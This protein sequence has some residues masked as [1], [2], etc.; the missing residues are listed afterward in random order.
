MKAVD[1]ARRTR[2]RHT[3][4]I[5]TA[6]KPAWFCPRASHSNSQHS[7]R[8]NA[9]PGKACWT[10]SLNVVKTVHSRAGT[11]SGML[12]QRGLG[13][14][15]TQALL[16]YLLL[17]A[18]CGGWHLWQRRYRQWQLRGM[19]ASCE[20][21]NGAH[22]CSAAATARTDEQ[23]N[24]G[25]AM[26][27]HSIDS[28][29]CRAAGLGASCLEDKAGC[30][31]MACYL[32]SQTT[33]PVA[34]ASGDV[35]YN[36]YDGALVVD[37]RGAPEPVRA[38]ANEMGG[39]EVLRLERDTVSGPAPGPSPFLT[40]PWHW[41]ASLAVCDVQGN[42]L[43]TKVS[44]WLQ[45]DVKQSF[46]F[47]QKKVFT[48]FWPFQPVQCSRLELLQQPIIHGG[49]YALAACPACSCL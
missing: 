47:L 24:G 43:V 37:T 31:N 32:D 1:A 23:Q 44:T 46:Y 5:R 38:S 49:N 33:V 8:Y 15:T 6:G 17:A 13:A 16:N 26:R 21:Q 3:L 4:F 7:L 25:R 41:Y 19:R 42:F 28:N 48:S 45:A 12:A 18:T 9:W 34:D 40:H 30:S 11:T 39:C 22:H 2:L 20:T 29:A 14:P 35:P 36:G 10:H 27:P